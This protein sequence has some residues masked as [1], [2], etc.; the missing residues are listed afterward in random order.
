MSSK[1]PDVLIQTKEPANLAQGSLARRKSFQDE[2]LEFPRT[3]TDDLIYISGTPMTST[4]EG[5]PPETRP[6][7]LKTRVIWVL[8]IYIYIYTL[9]IYPPGV[10][11]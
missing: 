2:F 4:F 3:G 10:G 11:P 7:P 6:F 1:R 5:Q 9:P 8:G